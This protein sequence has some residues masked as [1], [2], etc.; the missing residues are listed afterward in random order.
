MSQVWSL[1]AWRILPALFHRAS[2]AFLRNHVTSQSS[3]RISYTVY[4]VPYIVYRVRGQETDRSD[5]MLLKHNRRGNYVYRAR[6]IRR[7]YTL[8]VANLQYALKVRANCFQ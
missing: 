5:V 8:A 1:P 4:R 7:W 6:H 2:G 3:Y